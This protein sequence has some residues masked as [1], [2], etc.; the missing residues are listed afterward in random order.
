VNA[1]ATAV[2][3]LG[4]VVA[5]LGALWTVQGLGLVEV[6]PVLCLA[7]CDPI[8]GGSVQWTVFGAIA[9]LVGLVLVRAGLRRVDR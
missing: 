3:V 7:D 2:T 8:T 9:L 4:V 6:R 1:K 5:L